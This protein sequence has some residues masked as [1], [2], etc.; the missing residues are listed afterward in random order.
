MPKHYFNMPKLSIALSSLAL[1]CS[2]ISCQS[3]VERPLPALSSDFTAVLDAHGDWKK[4]YNASA[5]SY[6][7]IH[8]GVMTEE[9]TF[10]NLESRKIRLS[11][12][13]FEIGFDGNQTWISP[14]RSAYKGTSVK[15]YH[16][17][18]FYFFNIPYV[19]TDPGVSVEKVADK[20]LNGKAY[21]TYQAKFD[22]NTGSSPKDKYFMLINPETNRLEYLLY[23]VTYYGNENPTFSALKYEDYR[24]SDGVYFPR[25][26]TGYNFENDSTKSIKYQ[27]TFADA[28]LLDE[29]FDSDI[30]EK[31]EDAVYA[32]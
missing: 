8:E 31:P 21:P 16:N 23:T 19:F 1:L 10:I 22:P 25:I 9:N 11:N 15:F 3:K 28:L 24:N 18:Y 14:N 30:F 6:S 4:W 7:M 27:V 29:A 17:L 12:S 32:D 5:E 20:T 13:E 26:L 2:I